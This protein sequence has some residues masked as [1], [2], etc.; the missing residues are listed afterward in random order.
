MNDPS[1]W[2]VLRLLEW[3]TGYLQDQGSASARLDAEV[4][5]A[6]AMNC[7]RIEL[8]TSFDQEASQ[9]TRG[10]FRELVKQRAAGMPVAYLVGEKEFYSRSFVVT[11]DVLVPRPETEFVLI[12][13]LDQIADANKS[14]PVRI[15]DV[16][17]GSGILAVCAAVELPSATVTAIDISTA[18]LDVAREN[19]AR[20]QVQDRITFLHGDLFEAIPADVSY[21]YIISNPPYVGQSEFETLEATVRDYEPNVAL[22]A[23]A[24]G[25][26]IIDRI[27]PGAAERLVSGGWLILEVSPTICELA[28]QSIVSEG[29]FDQPSTRL[30]LAQLPRVV[31]AR[32]K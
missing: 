12:E 29:S 31:K 1:T 8:Y 22:V 14:A 23:G 9:E 25:T 13:L 5:L 30:D 32:R 3:T 16:G 26:E 20:H 21:D 17:T 6:K 19:A 15:L 18:A 2:T 24:A 28:V 27:V 11:P 10:I 4:L 7:Q